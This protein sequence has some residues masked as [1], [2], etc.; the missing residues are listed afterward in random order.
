MVN[1]ITLKIKKIKKE[2]TGGG[3]GSKNRRPAATRC[4]QETELLMVA[5]GKVTHNAC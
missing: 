5:A 3:D 2:N 4:F 1:V